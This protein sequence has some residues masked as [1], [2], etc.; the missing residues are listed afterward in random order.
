[1]PTLARILPFTKDVLRDCIGEG[2]TAIDATCGNG[3]DTVFLSQLVGKEGHVL[4]FDV[5][6][7]AVE[8]AGNRLKEAGIGNVTLILDG[9][10]HVL[11]YISSEIS[12]AIFNLGYLPG[13]DKS[14]TTSG[15]TTW[16]AVVDMLSLLKI[17]GV[18]VLVIYHGHEEGKRERDEIEAQ[19]ATLNPGETSVLKYEFLNRTAAPYVVAIEKV[20]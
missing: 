18:I 16:K 2:D 6:Q 9:H 14:V 4:A 7:V 8:R 19:I 3:N 13:S 20:K 15:E 12:A 17:G 10:E 5:Q 1:M 11:N